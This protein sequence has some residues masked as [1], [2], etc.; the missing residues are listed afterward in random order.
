MYCPFDTWNKST[1]TFIFRIYGSSWVALVST[2]LTTVFWEVP[3]LL[4][5]SRKLSLIAHWNYSGQNLSAAR[6]ELN[7]IHSSMTAIVTNMFYGIKSSLTLNDTFLP[8]TP[9]GHPPPLPLFEGVPILITRFHLF[10]VCL[11]KKISSN[12]YLYD[13]Y[14]RLTSL[15]QICLLICQVK[16][17]Y[18]FW[19]LLR[20]LKWI[21]KEAEKYGIS[22]H[23]F[24]V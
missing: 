14:L 23:L 8:S 6:S 4:C 7:F 21:Q 20:L 19:H 15:L 12:I 18:F 9:Q 17:Y 5:K 3:A 24:P 1:N 13:A 22:W 11:I 2:S 16:I 10:S